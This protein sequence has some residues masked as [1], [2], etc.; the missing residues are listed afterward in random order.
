MACAVTAA[1]CVILPT[2]YPVAIV[3][4]SAML[5]LGALG[6]GATGS[7]LWLVGLWAVAA[8]VTIAM[9]GPYRQSDLSERS[10]LV[11][12]AGLLLAAGAIA[13]ITVIVVAPVLRDPWT[14]PGSG[15]YAVPEAVAPSPGVP[16]AT[17]APDTPD[18]TT[19]DA[20][21]AEPLPSA[22]AVAPP[23]A[24][25]VPAEDSSTV[26]GWLA[27]VLALLLLLLLLGL[28]ALL[29]WRGFVAWRWDRTRRRL[30]TGPPAQQVV[31][32]WTWVRLRRAHHERPLPVSLSPDVAV[33][34]SDAN[35]QPDVHAVARVVAAVAFNP[36]ASVPPAE[37]DRAWEAARRAGRPA[38][39]A[40]A[41]ARWR[42]SGR[43]PYRAYG[44]L[45]SPGGTS[46]SV[47]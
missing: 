44:T 13:V 28:V 21:E 12:F 30:A 46:S 3:P 42:W 26:V 25:P 32:A 9:V 16:P 23:D 4:A 27:R 45:T 2:Q 10:R 29:A 38:P 43:L 36:A 11:P 5:L 24:T 19:S 8:A 37:A 41:R 20:I 33:A 17:D 35:A 14:I 40:G 22:D 39:G 7:V 1:M 31:G 47:G 15:T 18:S 34:W 6:L